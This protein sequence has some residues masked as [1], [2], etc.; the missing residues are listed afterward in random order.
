MVEE[1]RTLAFA[2]AYTS[3]N[4]VGQLRPAR[5]STSRDRDAASGAAHGRRPAILSRTSD[6][7]SEHCGDG[8]ANL[9]IWRR[10]N[11]KARSIRL[12]V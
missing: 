1:S 11:V 8:E 5:A 4:P 6:N 7:G 9:S 2:F 12:L 3:I 10:H